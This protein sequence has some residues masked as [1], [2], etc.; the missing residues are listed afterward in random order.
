M[1]ILF[2]AYFPMEPSVGGIQRV[3]DILVKELLRRGND[4][5]C[6]SLQLGPLATDL[7]TAPQ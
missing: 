2:L 4:V 1:N 3:T 6:L 7:T 5:S